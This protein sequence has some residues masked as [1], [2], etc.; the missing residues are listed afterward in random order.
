MSVIDESGMTGYGEVLSNVQC[1]TAL[2][3]ELA[4][5]RAEGYAQGVED[6]AGIADKYLHSAGYISAAIYT[7]K[8]VLAAAGNPTDKESFTVTTPKYGTSESELAR[9]GVDMLRGNPATVG[10]EDGHVCH[11]CDGTGI[12]P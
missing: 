9:Q 3:K 8:L 12:V 4:T 10:E 7:K 11:A 5:A 1:D 2:R 6:A